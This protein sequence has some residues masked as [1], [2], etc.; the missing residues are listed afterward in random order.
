MRV[1]FQRWIDYWL[2]RPICWLLSVYWACRRIIPFRKVKAGL[3]AKKILFLELSEM[4]SAVLAYP[5]MK[6]VKELFPQAEIYFLTFSRNSEGIK[7][8]DFIPPDHILTIRDANIFSFVADSIRAIK[9]MRIIGIEVLI[10]MELFSRFSAILSFFSGAIYRVGFS[11]FSLEGLYRGNM[12]T[13]R[14]FYNPYMHISENFLSLVY[15]LHSSSRGLPMF[16]VP[17]GDIELRLPIR[18]SD[19][20]AKS[21]IRAKLKSGNESFGERSKIVIINPGSSS[22]LPLRQWPVENYIRLTQMLLDNQDVMVAIIG[23]KKDTSMGRRISA[24]VKSPRCLNLIGKTSLKELIDLFN[25]SDLFISH[26]SGPS[27]F[28]AL[29]DIRAIVLFGPESPRLYSPLTTNLTICSANF[30][31]SPCVSAYNHRKSFCRDNR[32]LKAIKVKQVY[33]VAERHL[34]NK[35]LLQQPA[36]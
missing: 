15:S 24:A 5:A 25:I 9:T 32:C 34:F 11:R 19:S 3:T 8:L 27:H 22:L 36:F 29:T 21:A 10:D 17:S 1:G 28:V 33:E 26:D 14:V 20:E 31:C 30:A 18:E 7:I 4:G 6:R 2:G 23:D 16:R 12:Q 35:N 13:H